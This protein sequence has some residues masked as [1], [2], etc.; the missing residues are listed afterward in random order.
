ME[1]IQYIDKTI[2]IF[3]FFFLVVY[4]LTLVRVGQFNKMIVKKI[5][6]FVLGLVLIN[7]CFG[8]A[9]NFY[10]H[11]LFSVHMFQM[12]LLFFFIPVLIL[13]G[14]SEI[15]EHPRFRL[16]VKLRSSK[17]FHHA[18]L[19]LFAFMF[20]FYHFPVVFNT[21]MGH[22]T[23]HDFSKGFLMALSFLVWWPVATSSYGE[24]SNKLKRNYIYKMLILLMP[25]CLFLIIAN[26]GLY[27]VYSDPIFFR[28]TLHVC[29]S[30]NIDVKQYFIKFNF[31]ST[32]EDQRLG[33]TIMIISH[34][35]ASYWLLRE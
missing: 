7:L 11:L 31:L 9:L 22:K 16:L 25:A 15:K 8:S 19:G 23:L 2:L 1:S 13:S 27:K 10:S 33:G 18:I 14:L 3:T 12:S 34:K 5:I 28:E 24:K 20:S 4:L 30:P 6:C 29:F 26:T 21:V 17:N 32:I 35:L